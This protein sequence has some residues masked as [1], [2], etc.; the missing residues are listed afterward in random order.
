[1]S[2]IPASVL[3]EL[4][5]TASY[6]ATQTRIYFDQWRRGEVYIPKP[7][8]RAMARRYFVLRDQIE[9]TVAE[10][11]EFMRLYA[12]FCLTFPPDGHLPSPTDTAVDC[13]N[14]LLAGLPVSE[15]IYSGGGD[16]L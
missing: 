2:D 8:L 5:Q 7:A 9:L 12:W 15:R 10:G 1:M 16:D 11:Q 14:L 3:D 4:E 13:L 6:I